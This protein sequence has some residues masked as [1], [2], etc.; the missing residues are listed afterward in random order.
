MSINAG[1]VLGDQAA[2]EMVIQDVEDR[3]ADWA[4]IFILECDGW[5]DGRD[6]EFRLQH[7]IIRHWP[8]H[9]SYAM[10]VI[11]NRKY[12][13]YVRSVNRR[14]RAMRVHLT[15]YATTNMN[16]IAMHGGHGDALAPSLADVAFLDRTRP[17]G[18]TT[19]LFGDFNIDLLPE[20]AIDPFGDMPDRGSRHRDERESLNDL[21]QTMGLDL[22]V[23]D[24][25]VG[26]PGGP[27]SEAAVFSL[28]SRTPVG[29][30][31][32]LPSLLDFGACTNG[33][34]ERSWLDWD[35]ARSDHAALF[36]SLKGTYE[37]FKRRPRQSWRC[38]DSEAMR[39][40]LETSAPEQFDDL[41]SLHSFLARVRETFADRQT[42]AER[43]RTREPPHVKQ[44][45]AKLSSEAD[46][47]QR[48]Y[49]R[50]EIYDAR[51]AFLIQMKIQRETEAFERGKP[52]QK[53]KSL[54]R[55]ESMVPADESVEV[56]DH[57][58]W[59]GMIQA[60]FS[61]K[62]GSN[63]YHLREIVYDE[64][65]RHEGIGTILSDVD[66][67]DSIAAL[68]KPHRLDGYGICPVL[69]KALVQKASLA[70]PMAL[71]ARLALRDGRQP[72]LWKHHWMFPLHK[73]LDSS[74]ANSIE[75]YIRLR[76]FQR[77]WKDNCLCILVGY[78]QATA[79]FGAD[80]FAY[81]P[82]RGNRDALALLVL[83]WVWLYQSSWRVLL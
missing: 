14:G 82:N 37:V 1:K 49:L 67:L 43:R 83:Q 81:L 45:R 5:L 60:E 44:L 41:D 51:K 18:S 9:G 33:C 58:Q 71:L 76:S 28:I 26:L 59:A 66:V 23:P 57:D 39:A 78:L 52:R 27:H 54:H 2:W 56:L 4:A 13:K 34:I 31:H 38:K 40:F 75:A 47:L 30:Q 53:A 50:K 72:K 35:I 17:R 62:W 61:N 6:C 10:A 65:G 46:E 3:C 32:G 68:R 12:R 25:C 77:L 48:L 29:D 8:G 15:D 22:R 64:L 16:L 36:L 69:L 19:V 42:A 20:L 79:G 63:N 74:N 55:I 21:L 11:I 24:W 70:L 80:Q 73:Q 7:D